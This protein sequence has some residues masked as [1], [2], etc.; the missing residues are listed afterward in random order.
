ML[1]GWIEN[2]YRLQHQHQYM[3]SFCD[4][5]MMRYGI[6]RISNARFVILGMCPYSLWY[7]LSMSINRYRMLIYYPQ[8][9]TLQ[10]V[11]DKYSDELL[12]YE[13]FEKNMEGVF[14][15]DMTDI[16]YE[17]L[18]ETNIDY[19]HNMTEY[20]DNP[21]KDVQ[22]IKRMF[23]KPYQDTFLEN[24]TIIEKAVKYLSEFKIN[25]YIV[26]MPFP[27]LFL[28]NRNED[29]YIHIINIFKEIE[30]HSDNVKTVDLIYDERFG[31]REFVDCHHLNYYGRYNEVIK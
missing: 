31:N 9:H 30:Q 4:Y 21:G 6:E 28:D 29:M 26:L 1:A 19:I 16:M 2:H 13:A 27:K 17:Y 3:I 5:E 10:H 14:K 24:I 12:S 11:A 15:S 18:G 7:D 23:N 20:E 25:L 22:Q 8:T